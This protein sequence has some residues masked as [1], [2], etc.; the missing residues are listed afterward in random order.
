[1]NRI[2]STIGAAALLFVASCA[3][4]VPPPSSPGARGAPEPE[5]TTVELALPEGEALVYRTVGET[6][7]SRRSPMDLPAPERR[8]IELT[9]TL[10]RRAG[11]VFT[12]ASGGP[13]PVRAA[14]ANDEATIRQLLFPTPHTPVSAE[15]GARDELLLRGEGSNVGQRASLVLARTWSIAEESERQ[16]VLRM[17]S[18]GSADDQDGA[19]VANATRHASWQLV[20]DPTQQRYTRVERQTRH[21]VSLENPSTGGT[22]EIECISALRYE[23]DAEASAVR[24]AELATMAEE[25]AAA[26]ASYDTYVA[27]H[28]PADEIAA[29]LASLTGRPD[30]ARLGFYLFHDPLALWRDALRSAQRESFIQVTLV[31]YAVNPIPPEV[32]RLFL[33]DGDVRL[34]A[35]V[36][37]SRLPELVPSLEWLAA[38]AESDEVAERAQDSLDLITAHSLP[39]MRVLARQSSV[40]FWEEFQLI[41]LGRSMGGSGVDM[42]GAAAVGW[43]ELVLDALPTAEPLERIAAL[44]L[45]EELSGQQLGDDVTAWRD[46]LAEHGDEP[47]ARWLE[48]P[49]R[50]EPIHAARA[51]RMAAALEPTEALVATAIAQL[52]SPARATRME[53][54]HALSAWGDARGSA[55][56]VE[57]LMSPDVETRRLAFFAL[58]EVA[59]NP[60]G[61]DPEGPER[62]RAVAVARW[63]EWS[64]RR[65]S[66]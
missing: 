55:A 23:L 5:G 34:Q 18:A 14:S 54:A 49:A 58:A 46:F 48:E 7:C 30:R 37:N 64:A 27:E 21:I 33:E 29:T 13:I 52:E 59:D 17:E 66:S 38:E 53:A 31:H 65:S 45:L 2:Q 43:M 56:L 32:A 12:S 44:D 22:R 1:M 11:Q 51:L 8:P 50:A 40:E 28:R 24:S 9:L 61:F 16:L 35:A 41:L 25:A 26:R 6:T 15:G 4:T 36:A 19:I 62:Q 10:E 47:L 63:R 20:Y 42:S 3:G 60:L 57:L 39:A